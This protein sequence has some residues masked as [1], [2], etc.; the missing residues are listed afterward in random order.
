MATNTQTNMREYVGSGLVNASINGAGFIVAPYWALAS[1]A[2]NTM[3]YRAIHNQ[4]FLKM[5][6][7]GWSKPKDVYNSH[8]SAALNSGITSG[9]IVIGNNNPDHPFVDLG[10]LDSQLFYVNDT[11]FVALPRWNAATQDYVVGWDQVEYMQIV[12]VNYNG[13]GD[14]HTLSIKRGLHGTTD[15]NHNIG[16]V[17]GHAQVGEECSFFGAV[18]AV[19]GPVSLAVLK[20]TNGTDFVQENGSNIVIEDGGIIEGRFQEV[21][22]AP[23]AGMTGAL[24]IYKR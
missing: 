21:K 15:Q 11:I 5:D 16:S 6:N 17:V 22:R 14:M 8:Y 24:L 1:S 19:G 23:V 3:T 9:F 4:E 18:K 7:H 2:Y 20:D 12:G 10:I 13:P